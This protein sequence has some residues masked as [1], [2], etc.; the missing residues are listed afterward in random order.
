M[1]DPLRVLMVEDSATDAKLVVQALRA[2][3]STVETERVEDADALRAA[4]EHKAWDVVISDWSMPGFSG[5]AA[6]E[7]VKSSGLDLPFII[8]SGTMGEEA[9]V[10]AMRAGA[11]DYVL[12]DK[13]VRLRPAVER[14][15]RDRD[16]REARR[17]AE[18]NARAQETRFRALI[19]NSADAIT[20]ST[21][22]G[23]LL[24]V[25]PSLARMLGASVVGLIGGPVLELV[26]PDDRDEVA[27]AMRHIRE[28]GVSTTTVQYR[29]SH[30]DGSTVWLE[31]AATN[32]LDE[33]A[34]GAVVG[35]LRNITAQKRALDDLRLSEARFKRLADSGIVGIVI[36]DVHGA[37]HETN[38]AYLG[39]MGYTRD[40]LLAGNVRW[41][42][43]TPPE[44]K[45]LTDRAVE[46]L[47][48]TGVAPPWESELLRKDGSRVPVLVTVAMLESPHCIALVTDLSERKKGEASLQR[49]EEQLRQAQ[50]MEAIGSLAGGVAHDFNN[51]LSVIL[52]YSQMILDDLEANDPLRSD[53]DEIRMAGERAAELTRQLLMFSRRQVI[54]PRVLDLNAVLVGLD[55]MLHR[56]LGE[57]IDLVSLPGSELG[58]VRADP[59]S[60][61]QVVMNLVVNARDA[62]PTGGQLT[63]E[64]SNVDLDEVFAS[65]NHDVKPGAYVMLAV[66]DTGTG[67]DKAT[68]ARIF[69]PF[70]TTKEK[71]KG[72]G[73]GLST[74][75]GIVQQSGGHVWVY[76]EVGRG[77]SFKVYLPRVDEAAEEIQRS[78]APVK[79][80]G[81]ETILLVED[82]DQVRA[83]ARGILRKH[84][85]RVIEASN[86]GEAMLLCE[87]EQGTIHLLLTDVVMPQM[88]GP[89]LAK[90]LGALRQ[91]MKVLYM[92]GYTDDAA[93]RHGVLHSGIAYL[94]KPLTVETL[95]RK[96]RE[97]LD[98]R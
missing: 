81:T 79:L 60:V 77:T 41:A 83:V 54:E 66:S 59:G 33:P 71:G 37:I 22:D 19:E 40:E 70:F 20:M 34:V 82:E 21:R 92:S 35:N 90:R 94:Q 5:L 57:D 47:E 24:Y 23:T 17:A 86:A 68:Q 6:L 50:K 44:L 75:F 95:T 42:D 45:H 76:S 98:S 72:T 96:V 74:V 39:L 43:M 32:L 88:S 7:I 97:V 8:V 16:D 48:R 15:L 51:V 46:L 80:R 31:V 28:P 58:R 30:Q 93:F 84:G 64:T 4:L 65:S 13:L 18:K 9:A 10:D 3:G 78:A 27:R 56:L 69:E 49:L 2:P 53:V 87:K 85:Y 11:H 25:S 63:L 12:K 1:N 14:E 38:D 61:E 26:H 67:M 89:E 52:S 36:A 62:M 91:D 73:L 29:A 55:K